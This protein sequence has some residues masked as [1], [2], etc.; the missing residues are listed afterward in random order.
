MLVNLSKKPLM[1]VISFPDKP[2]QMSRFIFVEN[3][4]GKSKHFEGD[5]ESIK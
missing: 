1:E 5:L 4:G 3:R 2:T